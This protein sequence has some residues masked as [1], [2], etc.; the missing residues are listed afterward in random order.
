MNNVFV[1]IGYL[2]PS[3]RFGPGPKMF[4]ASIVGYFIGKLSYQSVCAEKLM[5]LPNSQLGEIL[6]K[7]KGQMGFQET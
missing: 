3:L 5:A 4:L 6:R 2:K 1:L 7:K